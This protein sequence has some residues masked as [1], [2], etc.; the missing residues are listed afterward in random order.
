MKP[1][2]VH[3]WEHMDRN[4]KGSPSTSEPPPDNPSCIDS[5]PGRTIPNNL[6]P[7]ELEKFNLTYEA[8]RRSTRIIFANLWV[9]AE[10]AGANAG[11]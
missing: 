8:W 3:L 6:R 10:G 1:N 9:R 5:L 11:G 7:Y 4:K 2:E